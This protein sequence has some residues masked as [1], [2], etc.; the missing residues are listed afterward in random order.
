MKRANVAYAQTV[1]N[2]LKEHKSLIEDIERRIDLAIAQGK[3]FAY[4]DKA[5]PYLVEKN[6]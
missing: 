4:I 6:A 3:T 5:I 1:E 2:Q